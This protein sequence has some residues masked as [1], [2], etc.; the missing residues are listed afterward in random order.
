LSLDTVI[1]QS[2]RSL[3]SGVRSLVALSRFVIKAQSDATTVKIAILDE[4][5]ATVDAATARIINNVLRTRLDRM[6]LVCVTH[7]VIGLDMFFDKVLV[8][9]NG[10]VVEYGEPQELLGR[11]DSALAAMVALRQQRGRAHAH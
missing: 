3:S 11:S 1:T 4:P 6:T 7:D 9:H 8:M 5:T 2:G 10:V